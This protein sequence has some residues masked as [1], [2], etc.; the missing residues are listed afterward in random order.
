MSI[1]PDEKPEQLVEKLLSGQAEEKYRGKQV[2]VI[3]ERV[4]VLPEDDRE[5]AALIED[6]ERQYPDQIPHLVFVPRSETY[7]V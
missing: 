3:D 7:A 2:V 5:S 1:Q 6:L 4:F